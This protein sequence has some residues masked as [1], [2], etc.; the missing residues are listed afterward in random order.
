MKA[1][2]FNIQAEGPNFPRQSI[3]YKGA[4]SLWATAVRSKGV[5]AGSSLQHR[6]LQAKE[7]TLEQI[8]H[9]QLSEGVNLAN[10]WIL[11]FVPTELLDNAFPD[12]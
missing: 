2:W 8:L 12:V 10:S 11:N 1:L 7:R 4:S 3:M 9:S 5:R 6:C